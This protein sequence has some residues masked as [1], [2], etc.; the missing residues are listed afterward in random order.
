[1]DNEKMLE[2]A[3]KRDSRIV[4]IRPVP[5][6]RIK[7]K[8]SAEKGTRHFTLGL[9]DEDGVE[10]YMTSPEWDAWLAQPADSPL[11]E[12]ED[13]EPEGDVASYSVNPRDIPTITPV[14]S[15]APVTLEEA[16]DEGNDLPVVVLGYDDDDGVFH[17]YRA[18]DFKDWCS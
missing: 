4:A 17:P 8:R 3:R 12:E 6:E 1:M 18:K 10:R 11:M 14:A 7:V 15:A 9:L 13:A 2:A 5:I 16:V